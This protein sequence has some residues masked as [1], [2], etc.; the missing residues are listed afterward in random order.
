MLSVFIFSGR[1]FRRLFFAVGLG[2]VAASICYPKEAV[3]ITLTRFKKLK[4]FVDE[5][6]IKY[7]QSTSLAGSVKKPAEPEVIK[8]EETGRGVESSSE[9]AFWNKIPFLAKLVGSPSSKE[10]EVQEEILSKSKAEKDKIIVEVESK[11]EEENVKVEGDTG[12]SNPEDKDLYSTR[13]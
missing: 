6:R 1:P 3:D 8:P 10:S 12:M 4:D 9:G 13:S 7:N 2:T 11:N 5:Q